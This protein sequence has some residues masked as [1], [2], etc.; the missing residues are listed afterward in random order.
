MVLRA[1]TW[2]MRESICDEQVKSE[3][4]MRLGAPRDTVF[5]PLSP[6]F[7]NVVIRITQRSKELLA[8]HSNSKEV[9]P[10]I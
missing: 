3:R 2:I 8:G 10:F 1:E 4:S 5:L 7:E 6:V 9:V